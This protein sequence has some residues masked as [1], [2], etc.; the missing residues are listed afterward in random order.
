MVRSAGGPSCHRALGLPK[1]LSGQI[2]SP[3]TSGL[4]LD[5]STAAGRKQ[6]RPGQEDPTG[7]THRAWVQLNTPHVP[8]VSQPPPTPQCSWARE[9]PPQT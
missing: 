5:S 6:P 2:P 9:L 3:E 4:D 7:H 8:K 1:A